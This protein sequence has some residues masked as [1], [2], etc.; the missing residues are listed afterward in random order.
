[1][2]G[3][4]APTHPQRTLPR[5]N[6]ILLLMI[7]V[8][9]AILA[10]GLLILVVA[11]RPVLAA[12]P[13]GN[14]SIA[15]TSQR[16]GNEEVYAMNADGADQTRLTHNASTTSTAT[17]AGRD[18]LPSFLPDGGRVAFTSRRPVENIH[19]DGG[20][21]EIYLV[22]A[23][24]RDGISEGDNLTRLTGDVE[25]MR[26]NF[27]AA[28]SADGKKVVFVGAW[29]GT[30]TN[31]IYVTD[32]VD[33]DGTN[34][35]RLPTESVRQLTDN[36]LIERSPAFSP[37]G[38][39]IAFSRRVAGSLDD[40]WAMNADGTGQTNLTSNPANDLFPNFSPDGTKIVF[41]SNRRAP[42]GT[43]DSEIYVMNAD[44][45]NP[46]ALTNNSVT[47]ESPDFSPD[48]TKIA[49]TSTRNG[50]TTAEINNKEI[51]VMNA[52]GSGP[53]RLTS[54]SVED[55]DPDWGPDTTA[56]STK[57]TI[58]EE[59][60]ANGWHRRDVTVSFSAGD[61]GGAGVYKVHYDSGANSA[62]SVP[63][64]TVLA[65]QL[66]A[67]ITLNTEG[68]TTL[69]YFATDNAGNAEPPKTLMVNLDKT[70]PQITVPEDITS[71]ATGP[72][73]A[74]VEFG[75]TATDN[76]EGDLPVSYETDY[77]PVVSGDTFP[78][79]TT[80]VT[81]TAVD[82]AGNMVTA[83]FEVT[84]VYDFQGFLSPVDNP[85]PG[86]EY[87]VNRAK[88]G[89]AIPVKFGLG[90][91]RGTT[92]PE[93]FAESPN[94]TPE[95]PLYYPVSRQV[96]TEFGATTDAIEETA[97]AGS[98]GLGYDPL[99]DQYTYV[100]KTDKSWGANGGQ[101]RELILKLADGTEHT[102]LFR[103]TK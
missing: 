88:A 65:G 47:D 74:A 59:A 64:T 41:S 48:G 46:V 16:D 82:R 56:P 84:V 77:G 89:S 2:N 69:N 38:T 61:H 7:T 73:G 44:G 3:M 37:D 103:F 72:S 29:T 12:L 9:V 66:P 23:Q 87:V 86:P 17:T 31:E 85:G 18:L 39:R 92:V 71:V 30:N 63:E 102:A 80:T 24:D 40:I 33:A 43:A 91:N 13:G 53:T 6:S 79:G 58:S 100:W 45:S 93:I 94:S 32:F 78:L 4:N 95:N 36:T 60:N 14:G 21:D 22:D 51:W 15:F 83:G 68:T 11:S 62:Q 26:H 52:D 98:S 34:S 67:H 28:F 99:T 10:A 90:G 20:I 5:R 81:A 8:G 76:V 42:D 55:S 75:A 19:P 35:A 97:N 25:G 50:N 101:H 27:G 54:N 1:M 49:F 96:P 70:E 57:A